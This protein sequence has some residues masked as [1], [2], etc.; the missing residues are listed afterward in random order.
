[1][2]S[3]WVAR[4]CECDGSYVF[5]DAAHAM[6]VCSFFSLSFAN[7]AYWLVAITA[8]FPI[9]KVLLWMCVS[10]WARYERKKRGPE[11]ICSP[12]V[13]NKINLTDSASRLCE[14][15]R[16]RGGFRGEILFCLSWGLT[17]AKKWQLTV[18][19]VTAKF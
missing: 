1:M 9:P 12:F 8:S 11:K 10:V 2:E 13:W 14:E 18:S 17:V 5:V 4:L 6:V 16:G 3:T 7:T 19:E 15:D